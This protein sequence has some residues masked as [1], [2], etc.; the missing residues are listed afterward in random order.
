MYYK[1]SSGNVIALADLA[2]AGGVDPLGLK[3]YDVDLD[4]QNAREDF[5]EE[6]ADDAIGRHCAN[7]TAKVLR[8]PASLHTMNTVT[9]DLLH[10]MELNPAVVLVL[11]EVLACCDKQFR[12]IEEDADGE[13]D[14]TVVKRGY[15]GWEIRLSP[16]VEIHWH[17]PFE[18]NVYIPKAPLSLC[19]D[20]PGQLLSRYVSHPVLDRFDLKIKSVFNGDTKTTSLLIETEYPQ[21]DKTALIQRYKAAKAA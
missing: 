10:H 1:M 19:D 12:L 20:M 2:V 11:A 7:V 6:L 14:D 16:E 21:L 17:Q 8:W 13:N 3:D 9:A 15:N 5:M 18:G 4:D